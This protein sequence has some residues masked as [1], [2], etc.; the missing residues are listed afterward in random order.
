MSLFGRKNAPNRRRQFVERRFVHP[1][2]RFMATEAAGGIVI[3]VAA[4]VALVW[5]NSPWEASYFD[6]WHT[7]LA[8]DFHLV[9][10]EASLGHLVND[11]L[12]V[13]FFFIVGLE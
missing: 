5:A 8:F 7:E 4:L 1:I 11:G 9:A 2:R 13:L 12:M 6:L 3:V 10:I